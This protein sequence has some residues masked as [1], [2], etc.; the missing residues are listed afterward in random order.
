MVTKDL[1]RQVIY[2][3][4]A[5][6]ELLGVERQVINEMSD[7]SGILVISG[8]RLCGKSVLMQQIRSKQQ[9]QDYYLNF[10]DDRLLHFTVEDF[11]TLHEV[12]IE[13]FGTQHTFYLDEPQLVP[14][15]ERFVVRLY[16]H[17]NKVY[18]TGDN[19]FM[20]SKELGKF[21][22]GSHLRQ[23]LYPM[24]LSEYAMMKNVNWKKTDFFT[25]E[26]KAKL[27]KLQTN[28]LKEGGF[29][30]Y[31]NTGD[32]RYLRELYN[33]IVYRDIV[34]R[35]KLPSER[36]IKE[37]AFYLASNYTHKFT[38]Q[39]VARAA[40]IKS[41]ETVSDYIGYLEESCLL[42]VLTKYDNKVG[43]Q[44]KSPKKA[45]FVDNGLVSQIGFSSTE[46]LGKKL[47]NAVYVELKRRGLDLFYFSDGGECDF[48]IRHNGKV[49]KACQVTVS[50]K[51]PV[52]QKK[53]EAGLLDAM[54]AFGLKEGLIVTLDEA[55]EKRLPDG[56]KIKA[57]PFYRWCL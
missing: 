50:L 15:W 27:N 41:A 39:S 20:L 34:I 29:P 9:E 10:D 37:V 13:D 2:E 23:E 51:D 30:Q 19:A 21:L 47:E 12:F 5:M 42:G 18:V 46:N 25:T 1:L 43:V 22:S 48:V 17:G 24:S 7:S 28:Y 49:V 8:V 32:S 4:R 26:G 56:R 36:K 38:Y 6:N 31:L 45:Y 16:N 57:V 54:N 44:V 33:D 53:K 3:Q 40:N 52:M 55:K 35:H 11:Q 14:G